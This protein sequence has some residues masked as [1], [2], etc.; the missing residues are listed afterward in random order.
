M[1]TDDFKELCRVKHEQVDRRLDAI[2]GRIWI[3]IGGA[4]VQMLAVIGWLFATYIAP[5]G[6]K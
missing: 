1:T 4:F 6:G 2:E 3:V 5:H